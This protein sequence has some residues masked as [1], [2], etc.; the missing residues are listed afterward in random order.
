MGKNSVRNEQRLAADAAALAKSWM[1]NGADR[2]L[3][4]MRNSMPT[5]GGQ[6][7]MERASKQQINEAGGWRAGGGAEL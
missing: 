4:K 5:L 2:F 7:G 6:I 1:E 3:P